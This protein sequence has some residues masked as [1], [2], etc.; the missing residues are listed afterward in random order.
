MTAFALAAT[1]VVL[2]GGVGRMLEMARSNLRNIPTAWCSARRHLQR[3]V[4]EAHDRQ[5]LVTEAPARLDRRI[6]C[7]HR[8]ELGL[9]TNFEKTEAPGSGR[10]GHRSERD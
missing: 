9:V 2:N 10:I 3:S 4:H 7:L 8:V 5:R 1:K 6:A